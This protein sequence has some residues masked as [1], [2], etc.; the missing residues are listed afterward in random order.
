MNV[1]D[2]KPHPLLQPYPHTYILTLDLTVNLKHPHQVEGSMAAAVAL[3]HPLLTPDLWPPRRGWLWPG[4][5]LA[6]ASHQSNCRTIPALHT[7]LLRCPISQPTIKLP[8]S[9]S[10]AMPQAGPRLAPMNHRH[11]IRHDVWAC[12]FRVDLKC[13]SMVFQV[14]SGTLD[15]RLCMNFEFSE[16]AVLFTASYPIHAQNNL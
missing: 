6:V 1:R 14:H 8:A 15:Q 7:T 16:A 12:A 2:A 4:C 9:E 13:A 5:R 11:H 10:T 3:H